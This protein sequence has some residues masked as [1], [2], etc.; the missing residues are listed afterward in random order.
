MPKAVVHG[1]EIVQVQVEQE[2]RLAG[3]DHP[4]QFV[5]QVLVQH[6]PVRQRGQRVV[7]SLVGESADA[8]ALQQVRPPREPADQACGQQQQPGH[9]DIGLPTRPGRTRGRVG[10]RPVS[11]VGEHRERRV[12]GPL[13]VD[14]G[15]GQL[16]ALQQPEQLIQ[17]PAEGLRAVEH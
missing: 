16:A 2:H 8:A 10:R 12:H 15:P 17:R 1:L 14:H 4:G 13:V 6:R 7:Q 9:P 11:N 5:L 3:A